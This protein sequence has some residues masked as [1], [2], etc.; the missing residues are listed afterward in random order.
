MYRP[1][2]QTQTL[3]VIF[4][5]VKLIPEHTHQS[6][7]PIQ[8]KFKQK[9]LILL[10]W[11]TRGQLWAVRAAEK[12]SEKLLETREVS[13]N[14]SHFLCLNFTKSLNKTTMPALTIG[15]RIC[16]RGPNTVIKGNN[17]YQFIDTSL[18]SEHFMTTH[19]MT[20]ITRINSLKNP[21]Q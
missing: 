11:G 18:Q 1:L 9:S 3:F 20:Q 21:N 15:I 6:T 19:L 8:L 2:K 12:V 16:N 10:A 17:E 13:G 5:E 4:V 14:R 7:S